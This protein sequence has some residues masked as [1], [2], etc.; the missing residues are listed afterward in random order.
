[1]F[2]PDSWLDQRKGMKFHS[3]VLVP[4]QMIVQ[5]NLD[6]AMWTRPELMQIDDQKQ[7]PGLVLL[8]PHFQLGE[9]YKW[10][11]QFS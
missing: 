11:R 6:G 9:H 3:K 10:N 2:E 7:N 4:L 1:M 8:H 5:T